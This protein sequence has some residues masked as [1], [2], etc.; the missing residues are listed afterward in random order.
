MEVVMR[1]FMKV[2]MPVE[3]GN[4]AIKEGILQRTINNFVE[5]YKPEA[6]YFLPEG[7]KRS[8]LLFFDLKEPS[9]LPPA[10]E[11]FFFNL[12]ADVQVSPV[13]NLEDVRSGIDKAL[14]Q[15]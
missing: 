7:G 15:I 12:N 1:V 6:C 13:M 14:K 5:Q 11:S 10:A 9:Q 4:K 3:A 8:M 2:T